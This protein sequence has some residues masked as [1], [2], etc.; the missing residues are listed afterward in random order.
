MPSWDSV[1]ILYIEMCFWG[2]LLYKVLI[3]EGE[4]AFLCASFGV[5]SPFP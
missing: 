2:A 1:Q 5:S 3:S 4:C